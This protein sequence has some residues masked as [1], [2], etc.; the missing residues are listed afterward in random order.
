[1]RVKNIRY[2]QYI[3][4]LI[5]CLPT[6]LRRKANWVGHILRRNCLLKRVIEGRWR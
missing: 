4:I 1:M 5:K 6:L 3:N 2:T